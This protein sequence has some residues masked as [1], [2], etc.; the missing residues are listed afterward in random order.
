MRSKLQ[1][2]SF[3]GVVCRKEADGNACLETVDKEKMFFF[4][5]MDGIQEMVP[6]S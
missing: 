4:G 6:G 3:A 2:F 5:S 1:E